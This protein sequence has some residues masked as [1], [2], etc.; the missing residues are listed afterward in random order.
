MLPSN[1]TAV[2]QKTV[3]IVA[4][5]LLAVLINIPFSIA[6]AKVSKQLCIHAK[7][8]CT[9]NTKATDYKTR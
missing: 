8:P 5:I 7:S 3:E 9:T 4:A 2:K 1:F 6:D